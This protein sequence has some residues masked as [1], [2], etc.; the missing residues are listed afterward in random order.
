MDL[1]LVKWEGD[2][3]TSKHLGRRK[4]EE[5]LTL[6]NAI[7][8][9]EEHFIVAGTDEEKQRMVR[10]IRA[11][12]RAGSED[13]AKLR[14]SVVLAEHPKLGEGVFFQAKPNKK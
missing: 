11:A 10:K 8:D 6:I 9:G 2:K 12:A 5:T 4:S 7:K 13:G 3:P 1:S 14:V